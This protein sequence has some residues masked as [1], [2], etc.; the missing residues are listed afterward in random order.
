MPHGI[1]EKRFHR[2]ECASG[3]TCYSTCDRSLKDDAATSAIF[4]YGT[5]FLANDLPLPR[6]HNHVWALFHEESPKNNWLFC[7]DDGIR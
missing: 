1:N 3:R 7:H 6:N 4:F 5:A 2:I